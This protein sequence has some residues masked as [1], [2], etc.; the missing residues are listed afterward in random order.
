LFGYLN[1]AD[2]IVSM[3]PE[4]VIAFIGLTRAGK[5]ATLNSIVNP[6]SLIGKKIGIN[7]YY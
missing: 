1:K 6:D 5:S 2:T 7:S 4:C 3:L